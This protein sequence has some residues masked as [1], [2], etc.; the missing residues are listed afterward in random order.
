M[1][2]ELLRYPAYLVPTPCPALGLLPLLRRRRGLVT[3]PRC[4]WPRSRAS[5]SSVSRSSSSESESRSTAPRRGRRT[6]ARFPVGPQ[7]ASAA[8]LLSAAVFAGA[9]AA[10]LVV[11]ARRHDRR[12]APAARWAGLAAALVRRRRALRVPRDRA[13]ILG[14]RAGGAADREPA[15]PRARR[16]RAASGSGPRRLPAAVAAISP[17]LP[18]RAS[19]TRSSA[20]ARGAAGRVATRGGALAAFAALFACVAVAGYRRDEGRRFS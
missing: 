17:F 13:R 2:V 4:G 9:A 12:L 16:T 7:S 8:R 5:R 19:P 11:T 15:L 3:T 10:L 20:T 14:S 6:C 18:T 1:T